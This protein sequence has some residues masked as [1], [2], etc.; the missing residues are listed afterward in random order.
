M[1]ILVI[2]SII[3]VDAHVYLIPK[4]FTLY[5]DR[6]GVFEEELYLRTRTSV[7]YVWNCL[8]YL[9]T[10]HLIPLGPVEGLKGHERVGTAPEGLRPVLPQQEGGCA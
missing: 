8:G 9:C 7:V 3:F 6:G 5:S 4:Y 10:C 1:L 2:L